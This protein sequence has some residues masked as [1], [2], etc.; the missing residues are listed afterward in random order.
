METM[1]IL[2]RLVPAIILIVCG[3]A[4]PPAKA[5]TYLNSFALSESQFYPFGVAVDLAQN[6]RVLVAD[7]FNAQ[8]DVFTAGGAPVRTIPTGQY[9]FPTGIAIDPASDH[10]LVT[11]QLNGQVAIYDAAGNSFGIIGVPGSGDGQLN[12]PTGIAVD[13]ANGSANGSNVLVA[14]A[15]NN[16]IEVFSAAGNFIRTIGNG[17]GSLDGQLNTPTGVA[18]DTTNGSNVLVADQGNNRIEVFSAGGQFIRTIGN[19]QLSVPVNVAVD[20][21]NVLVADSGHNRVAVF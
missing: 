6:S 13:V 4:A 21:G 2:A 1:N 9:S 8:I 19:G 17:R 3:V 7:L 10:V 5:Q 15:R 11:E 14:D 16:R 12:S 20:R 18:V